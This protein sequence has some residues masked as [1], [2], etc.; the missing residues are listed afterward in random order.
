MSHPQRLEMVESEIIFTTGLSQ[1]S[2]TLKMGDRHA[3]FV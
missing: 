2:N 3:L 1:F